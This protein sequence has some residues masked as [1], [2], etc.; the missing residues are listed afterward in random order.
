MKKQFIKQ[1]LVLALAATL[2]VGCSSDDSPTPDNVGN[3]RF[4]VAVTAKGT[5]TSE[6]T[7]FIPVE[8]LDDASKSITPVGTGL[9]IN[10]TYSHYVHN[11]FESLVGLKYGQGGA[12][13]GLRV[14]IDPNTGNAVRIGQ[15]FELQDGFITTGKVGSTVYSAMS[16]NRAADKTKAT[17]NLIPL[18]QD[19]PKFAYMSVNAFTGYEGKNATIVG[20][21]DAGDG[22]FFTGL[23]FTL[24]NP[25][26]NDAVV[27]KIKASSLKPEAVY[28]DARLPLSGGQFKSARYSQ[29]AEAG[30]GDVY[31]FAGNQKGLKTAGALRIK[32]GASGFDADYFWDIEAETGYRFRKIWNLKDD[33]YLVEFFNDQAA[34][35]TA[36][37]GNA[38]NYAVLAME[39]K[40]L[41]WVTGLPAKADIVEG[42]MKLPFVYGGKAY[43][44]ITTTSSGE[45]GFYVLDPT[46]GAATK[47]LSVKNAESIA[48]ATY[49]KK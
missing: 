44:G 41:T 8:S 31:V 18:T 25:D 48:A 10:E 17:F 24:E 43:L 3:A 5:G 11:G 32:S 35:G 42:C 14:T 20:I 46:T 9:E 22:S 34:Q 33:I 12:H 6:N 23:D 28:T 4:L 38:T 1:S 39:S 47:G 2:A 26:M 30:N 40:K 16:G 21:A 36:S 19:E 13:L 15:A 45:S 49:I 37:S 27:A 29:I 7:Y